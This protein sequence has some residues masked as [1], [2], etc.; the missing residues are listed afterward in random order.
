MPETGCDRHWWLGG[1]KI[2]LFYAGWPLAMLRV[3]RNYLTVSVLLRRIRFTPQDALHLRV[4]E[5]PQ[6]WRW[7]FRTVIIEP[8]M[9]G[10]PHPIAFAHR[11]AHEIVAVAHKLGYGAS[12]PGTS[13]VPGVQG[14]Y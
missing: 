3:D 6:G 2:G 1:G 5:W 10:F 14:K 7:T 9:R 13:G 11:K 4:I 8:A 12:R